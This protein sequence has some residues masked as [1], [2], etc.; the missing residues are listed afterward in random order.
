MSTRLLFDSLI[1]Q[2]AHEG[3]E[4]GNLRLELGDAT[5]VFGDARAV[6]SRCLFAGVGHELAVT[7]GVE[8][9]FKDAASVAFDDAPRHAHDGAVGRHVFDHHGVAA[10]LDVIADGDIS[11][12]LGTGAHSDVVAQRGVALARLIA[13]S[14]Q[15]D[16][17]VE[18][19]IV[20]DDGGLANDDAHGMVDEE[21]PADMRGGVNFDTGYMA[22]YLRHD[23]REAFAAVVPQPV[24]GHMIP[25][26]VKAGIG[27]KDDKAVLRSGVFPLNGGDILA[28]CRDKA[29]LRHPSCANDALKYSELLGLM[30][31]KGS[32]T[33]EMGS[34]GEMLS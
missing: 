27:E 34:S 2:L 20:A 22:G 12:H 11:Q 7:L 26:C 16:A 29:H 3:G 14:A 5:S 24:L 23:T 28:N 25:F 13:G 9:L 21:V 33:R 4:L 15:G 32:F 8:G 17:L 6:A 18:G 1:G 31:G 19:A 30:L 10:D